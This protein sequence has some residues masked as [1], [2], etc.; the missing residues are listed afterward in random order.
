MAADTQCSFQSFH[1]TVNCSNLETFYPVNSFPTSLSTIL[2]TESGLLFTKFTESFIICQSHLNE[3]QEQNR[4]RKKSKCCGIPLHLSSHNLKNK[5][6]SGKLKADRYLTSQ[7]VE[8]ISKKY[9]SVLPVGTPIC[10]SC[11]GKIFRDSL[12]NSDINQSV[13]V[14][15]SRIEDPLQQQTESSDGFFLRPRPDHSYEY[16][17]NAHDSNVSSQETQQSQNSQASEASVANIDRLGKLNEFLQ[18]CNTSPVKK[19]R[20]PLSD[21]SERTQRRY[22]EKANECLS[23]LLETMCPGEGEQLKENIFSKVEKNMTRIDSPQFIDALVESYMRAETSTVRCQILSILSSH[24][25]F[26]DINKKIPSLTSHKFYTAKKHAKEFGVGAPVAREKQTRG[27]VDDA[28]LEHFLDFITSSHVIKDLPLGEKT[29]TLSSGELIQTPYVIRCLAPATIVKQYSRICEEENFNAIGESTMYKILSECSAAVRKSVEGVDY[30]VAEAGEAFRELENIVNQ[31]PMNNDG[32][33]TIE[34][35]LKAKHYLKTDYKMHVRTSSTIADHCF[36]HALSQTGSVFFEDQCPHD[37]IHQCPQCYQLEHTLSTILT[38]TADVGWDNPEAYLFKVE[39]SV[40]A[41]KELKS[42]ILRTKVQDSARADITGNLKEGEMFLVADWA[43]KFLPRKFREGQT[44]WFGKRGINWHIT[45]CATKKDGNFILDTY[46][47]ILD[48][49]TPQDSQLTAVLIADTVKDMVNCK[50]I[51]KVHIWSD[52]AGCYKSTFTIYALYQELP[53]LIKSYNFCEAQDGKGPCDR[54][55]SHIKAAIKRHVN[56][57][58]DVLN[59]S[60]MKRAIDLQQKGKYRVKVVTPVIDADA[61]KIHVKPIPNISTLSNFEFSS[62]GLK[63]WRAYKVGPGKLIPWKNNAVTCLQLNVVHTWSSDVIPDILPPDDESEAHDESTQP[64]FKRRKTSDHVFNCSNDDC[65]RSFNTMT[66][67]D[68]HLLLGNCNVHVEK[69]VV[70]RCKVMYNNKLQTI[71]AITIQS[72]DLEKENT[73]D[74][75]EERGW[76]LKVKKPKVL[77]TEAQKQYLSEKFNIGKV[78]GNKEDPAKVSRDMPYILKDGQKRFT[79][80]HFLTTSQVASYF[81]RLA[82]KDRRNDIQD[83]ND[84]TAASADKKL[85]GLKKK[86]LSH[87]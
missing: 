70:D 28:K 24:S 18:A 38:K 5:K 83:Q 34:N 73:T 21:S 40:N 23:L 35:L 48:A 57:G 62:D 84:F 59:A 65:D 39:K 55:A 63:V 47:H 29:L 4:L 44:D 75:P 41:I 11:R 53:N 58:N 17:E 6:R 50:N 22:T 2:L 3:L 54:K 81:S 61:E 9:G 16:Y 32:K 79:R 69:K 8:E 56:E 67:L 31:I 33:E 51:N 82:L 12:S 13:E 60:A 52:N 66:S 77:F 85:F 30:Y 42:H 80:E 46:V 64:A 49:Q 86:V 1:S 20:E 87:V 72:D 25:K 19:I 78:T 15:P 45:V 26:E 76:A 74:V 10:T 68:N 43:M 7:Q 36:V 37:H 14:V 71:N 27:R